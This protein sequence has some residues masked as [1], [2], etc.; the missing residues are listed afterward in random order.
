ML[1][2]AS[3]VGP[4]YL[5]TVT[6]GTAAAAAGQPSRS[7]CGRPPTCSGGGRA[8]GTT[9]RPTRGSGST[10]GEPVAATVFTRWGPDRVGLRSCSP[11]PTSRPRGRSPRSARPAGRCPYRDGRSRRRDRRREHAAAR[12]RLHSVRGRLRR[13]VARPGS[14]ARAAGDLPPGYRIVPRSADRSRPHPMIGRNGAR[15]E[16]ALRRVLALRPGPRSRRAGAGRRGGGLRAVLARP[17]H[18]CRAGRAD[19][20]RERPRRPRARPP[21][22]R[23]RSARAHRCAA[24]PG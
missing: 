5:D 3:P 11:T 12:R 20:G 24:A 10:A 22:A 13:V 7:R 23:R 16:D 4:D 9:I 19:A 6:L 18:R 2:V 8:T 14:A 21:P 15:V 17:G 1:T